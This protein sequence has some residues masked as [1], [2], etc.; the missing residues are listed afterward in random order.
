[1]HIIVFGEKYKLTKFDEEKLQNDSIEYISFSKD[2]DIKELQTFFT[3]LFK[4]N[5]VDLIVLNSDMPLP[6]N[7]RLLFI[8]AKE[9][10]VKFMIMRHFLEE[11]CKKLALSPIG[12]N[13]KL[14][15][16]IKPYT[17]F[18]YFLKRVIDY[19]ISIPLLIF[20]SPIMLYSIYR[21]KKESPGKILFIQSRI[22]LNNKPFKC[23]KF[24]SMHE[25]SKYFNHYTQNED[26]R[27]FAWGKI[28]RK[29][30]LDELPQIFNVL[31]GDMHLIGPRAEW[32]ELV[33]K[34][35]K[36]IEYYNLR[37]IVKP[38]ITGWAQVNYP[39]GRDLNDTKEKLMYD[40]YYIKNWSLWLELKTI[41]KTAL[42][43]LGKKGV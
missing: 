18:Q 13:A 1:M 38:G 33:Q 39:Y 26:P 37:H 5:I 23:Y 16:A 2:S 19:T 24:R 14:L 22:G 32:D 12:S 10:G 27:I 43:V 30:R 15:E 6:N 20:S 21:I 29:Y 8:K 7:L 25:E 36:E 42:V 40:L 35:E 28:M 17:K 31:K 11:Y 9:N 34:Y 4:Q 41:I 3:K